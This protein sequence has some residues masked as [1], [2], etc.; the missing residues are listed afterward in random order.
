MASDSWNQLL[1]KNKYCLSAAG[2]VQALETDCRMKISP[3]CAG[4][5]NVNRD[6]YAAHLIHVFPTNHR[7]E[8]D[9]DSVNRNEYSRSTKEGAYCQVELLEAAT[10]CWW[11]TAMKRNPSDNSLLRKDLQRRPFSGL[12]ILFLRTFLFVMLGCGVQGPW[13]HFIHL[14]KN[15]LPLLSERWTKDPHILSK[16]TLNISVQ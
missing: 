9:Q 2:R 12:L 11:T 1:I 10:C 16:K 4:L 15:T 7:L 5:Q 8:W 3:I 6:G 13:M 14:P